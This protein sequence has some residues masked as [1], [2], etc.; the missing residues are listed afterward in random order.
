MT[1]S[2]APPPRWPPDRAAW[3]AM[4]R[5]LAIAAIRSAIR[6]LERMPVAVKDREGAL[7]RARY[8]LAV[9]LHRR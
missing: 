8:A 7:D 3:A 6:E 4:K 5:E 9:A 1:T 2:T